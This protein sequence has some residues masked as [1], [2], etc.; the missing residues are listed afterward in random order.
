MR[1][2][3]GVLERERPGERPIA[4]AFLTRFLLARLRSGFRVSGCGELG[5][6]VS[7]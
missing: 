5:V 3:D 6:T 7:W 4:E 2:G 1:Y